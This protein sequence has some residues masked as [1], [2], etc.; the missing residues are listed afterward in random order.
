M[1]TQ[2]ALYDLFKYFLK[3]VPLLHTLKGKVFLKLLYIQN[4]N[5][6]NSL[7]VDTHQSLC[8]PTYIISVASHAL[9]IQDILKSVPCCLQGFFFQDTGTYF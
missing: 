5:L 1:L 7:L 9:V 3:N 2:I 8:S 6:S 4:P